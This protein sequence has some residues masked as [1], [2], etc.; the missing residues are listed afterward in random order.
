M[1]SKIKNEKKAEK[2]LIAAADEPTGFSEHQ[3]PTD[4]EIKNE[5]IEESLMEIYQDEN[6]ELANVSHFDIKKRRGMIFYAAVSIL[7]VSLLAG[8]AFGFF[9]YVYQ[10]NAGS[11]SVELSVRGPKEANSGEEFSYEIIYRN[12]NNVEINNTELKVTYPKNFIFIGSNVAAADKNDLWRLDSLGAHRSG[13]IEIKGKIVGQENEINTMLAGINYVPANFS[14]EFRKEA[15]LETITKGVGIDFSFARQ[16]SVLINE[17]TAISVKYKKNPENKLDNFRLSFANIDNIIFSTS[18]AQKEGVE[19]VKPGVWDFKEVKDEDELEIRFRFK[20]KRAE[21]EE[22]VLDFEYKEGDNYYKILEKKL[23]Y[24]MIRNELNLNLILNGS[25]NDQGIDF[26]QTLNYSIVYANKG[27]EEMKDVVIMAALNSDILDW[28]SLDDANKGKIVGNSMIWSKE[29]IPAL[30]SLEKNNEGTIDFSIK[31][32]S[33]EKARPRQGEQDKKYEVTGYAQFSIG[34]M[35][36][37]ESDST[38]S[39]VI[40]GRVNSDL[41]LNEQVRYFNEDNIAVGSGP[42]PPKAGETTSLKVDWT[43]TNN[44]HELSGLKV[45]T[46]LPKNVE[47]DGKNRTT[48]GSV[49]FDETNRRVIWDIGR[50]P[51]DVYE[52]V[53][54]FNIK[55]TPAEN[56]RGRIMVLLSGTDVYAVDTVTNSEIRKTGGAKTTKLED[57][58][59]ADTEGGLVN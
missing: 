31:A 19:A 55:V 33:L 16:N 26:G 45:E 14:S 4:E 2:A 53:A 6:G 5:E 56:D 11:G 8:A 52:I 32:L 9:K 59:I 44:L 27:E 12:L 15:A 7:S 20:D 47:W 50:L 40:I 54:E 41:K 38:K 36:T 51:M 48:V 22:V 3:L 49:S 57:D 58:D 35:E 30:A 39:N 29:E 10:K 37:K 34:N 25:R 18:T 23:P 24:E 13:R 42:I 46:I 21:T 43:L 1:A 28:S 17:E